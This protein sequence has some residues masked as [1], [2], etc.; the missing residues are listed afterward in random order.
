MG[1]SG[2]TLTIS[3]S[4]DAHGGEREER[5]ERLFEEFLYELGKLCEEYGWERP[6]SDAIAVTF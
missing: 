5:G 3:V 6:N 2:H 1:W 4:V